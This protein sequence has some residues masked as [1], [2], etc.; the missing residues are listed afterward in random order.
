MNVYQPSVE[1]LTPAFPGSGRVFYAVPLHYNREYPEKTERPSYF[2][3]HR[4]AERLNG[5]DI[6][7]ANIEALSYC[8]MQGAFLCEINFAKGNVKEAICFTKMEGMIMT[9]LVCLLDDI[10]GISSCFDYF[11]LKE[12][13]TMYSEEKDYILSIPGIK[14]IIY[15]KLK[16]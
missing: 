15:S 13:P 9:G 6:C 10:E 11:D 14:L 4:K 7:K 3:L 2:Y 8:L 5:Y 1:P 12:F 16:L